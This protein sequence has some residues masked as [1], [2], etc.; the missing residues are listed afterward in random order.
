MEWRHP[1]GTPQLIKM[2]LQACPEALLFQV[3]LQFIKL[4][5]E[6]N[7]HKHQGIGR[8]WVHLLMPHHFRLWPNA[9]ASLCM[10]RSISK[11]VVKILNPR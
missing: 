10:R 9:I 8:P 4:T 1:R 11:E 7:P 3:T 5:I 2:V 6:M